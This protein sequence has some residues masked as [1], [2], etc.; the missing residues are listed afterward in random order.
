MVVRRTLD[1]K[2]L[3][4]IRTSLKGFIT[5]FSKLHTATNLKSYFSLG[6]NFSIS[7]VIYLYKT[8]DIASLHHIGTIW[9]DF[10]TPLV[11]NKKNYC[12]F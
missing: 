12:I 5:S 7:G 10:P 8:L 9:N 11:A 3:S 6:F 4:H 2:S 1:M